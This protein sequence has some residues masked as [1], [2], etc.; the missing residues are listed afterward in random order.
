MKKITIEP[1]L[2][3]RTKRPLI[4]LYKCFL[5]SPHF[6]AWL[7]YRTLEVNRDWKRSYFDALC[8]DLSGLDHVKMIDIY[9]RLEEEI[10]RHSNV[11]ISLRELIVS[12][13]E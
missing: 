2:P 8:T 6:A 5:T 10:V 3:L 7:T 1:T 4:E 9:E 13:I 11:L 12:M